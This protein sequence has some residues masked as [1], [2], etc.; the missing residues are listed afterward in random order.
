MGYWIAPWILLLIGWFTPG[1]QKSIHDRTTHQT[2]IVSTCNLIVDAG[3]DTSICV[4]GGQ[5]ILQGSI[6]GNPA[7]FEWTPHIGLNNP[8]VL[9]P[10]ADISG[11]VTYTLNALGYDPSN[12]NLVINGDFEQGNTGF[13]T[14]QIFV[15]DD[16]GLQNE[17]YPDGTYTVIDNASLVNDTWTDCGDHSSGAG[18]NK[19][20]I[21][22]VASIDTI[23]CQTIAVLPHHY[24][25]FSGWACRFDSIAPPLFYVDFNGTHSDT[26]RTDS[27]LCV[28]EQLSPATWYS[29]DSSF[30]HI[31][32]INADTSMVPG[33]EYGLDDFS[34]YELCQVQD[35]VAIA[36]YGDVAPVP[37]IT[38]D[39]ILC[40]GD[41]AVY[42][43]SFPVGTN[44]ISYT[45]TPSS[46][47]SI[48]S[49]QGTNQVT[50]FWNGVG[51]AHVCLTVETNCE[52]NI[53]CLDFQIGIIP[54]PAQITGPPFLCP[55]EFGIYTVP[56]DVEV[57]EYNW[58]ITSGINII[59]G[60]GTNVLQVQWSNTPNA[61][62]CLEM[63]NECGTSTSC[64]T[65]TQFS[66]Y[67][68]LVD[69]VLCGTNTI[70]I[71]NHTY[72]NGIWSGTE[73]FSSSTGCDSVVEILIT[74]GN[75][76]QL[77]TSKKICPGDSIFLQ[78][79][80]QTQAGS[81]IDT[82]ASVYNCDSIVTTEV[83]ISPFDTAFIVSTTCDPALAGTTI[84]TIS[85]GSCDSTVIN[86]VILLAADTTTI[87]LYSCTV[88]D[89][90]QVIELLTNQVGCDS[91]VITNTYLLHS[92]TI[93]FFLTTCDPAMAG[94]TMLT[95]QNTVGCDSLVITTTS[96]SL[97]DTTLI[98]ALVCTYADTAT[99]SA[100]FINVMGCDSLVITSNIYA[101][102]DT[103]FI[104][105]ATCMSAN[106][107]LFVSNMTNQFGCDSIISHFV[108]LL[109]SDTT[110]I[111]LSSCEP[112]DTG[113]VTQ[114]LTNSVGCDSLVLTTTTLLP[115]NNCHFQAS[116][117][118]Q[119]PVCYGD[120]AW[121]TLDLQ[122]GLA[123]FSLLWVHLDEVGSFDFPSSGIYSFPFYIQGTS[124]V[125]L[126]SANG[127]QLLDTIYIDNISPFDIEI[128]NRSDYN[129]YNVPCHGDS[130][131]EA[132]VNI[133]SGGTLPLSYVW[134]NGIKTPDVSSLKAGVYNL[135]VTDDHGCT[136]SSSV[137]I[138]EPAAMEYDMA[139]DDI[140]CFGEQSGA[141]SL[142]AL[143]GGVGPYMTSL[144]SS[145]FQ[146]DL[147][148]HNLMPGDHA[149]RIIDQ[150]G[151]MREEQFILTE[152]DDW[153]IDLGRDTTVLYGT[154]FDL[155]PIINGQ[156][157]GLLQFL[158]S[159]QLCENCG[160][161]LIEMNKGSAF[162]VT[163]TDENGC[164]SEDEIFIDVYIKHDIYIPNIFS[165]NGD[166]VNDLLMI[167]T[168]RG[169]KEIEE[170]SVFDRWGNLV[171]SQLHVQPDDS[172][173]AWDGRMNGKPLNTG[174]YAYKLIAVFE[175]GIRVIKFGD[176]TL[177]R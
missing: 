50:V 155:V 139:I 21:N 84:T 10:T 69:T 92:D 6:G 3:H 9:H 129:G 103:T 12:Q 96:F 89:T 131:G 157:N 143:Q 75:A 147:S 166:Q 39:T 1:E 150:N 104:N 146:M 5:I 175:D 101:G 97:S 56:F 31:C 57:D 110:Y 128:E 105:S 34:F 76:F 132:M 18:V 73:L 63:V 54:F 64:F 11:P 26:I 46:A 120:S 113:V 66:G 13:Y 167:N 71:N 154:H 67:T 4:P 145:T 42:T 118:V 112:L 51:N 19:M 90:G 37:V 141:V 45:W 87:S 168:S 111:A 137:S 165:P 126:T 35:S 55:G 52:T 44:I 25:I 17:L 85:Q 119:Q 106:A 149:M 70:L 151:C 95:L 152:P 7:F 174:V 153:S 91:M 15:P 68:T 29:G 59:S 53:G 100:L 125:V 138:T 164:K 30:V 33:N 62:L 99:T 77:T 72:G 16:P 127:L 40:D 160:S 49:G 79:A 109:P 108:T 102:S 144:D 94:I 158:W 124:Y 177:I 27:S 81:Y 48:I 136:T 61:D 47:G 161:R 98:S 22:G 80:F 2:S 8:F 171:F 28:W 41:I 32:L 86:E 43:A 116:M 93:L 162:T 121:V 148:Y 65:I 114:Y 38:G 170:L 156:P 23:W 140:L 36:L 134:S 74:P 107:G 142:S 82:F 117:V 24:Y 88:S 135:T 133:I 78:G 20:V 176:I 130:I 122:V 169:L 115:V 173:V 14:Q 159:D 60:Q 163:A 83:I 172:S 123:P 58:S